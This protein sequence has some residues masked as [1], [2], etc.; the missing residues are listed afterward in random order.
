MLPLG[1][2]SVEGS[3]D[4]PLALKMTKITTTLTVTR[5]I[6]SK[7]IMITKLNEFELVVVL[8]VLMVLVPLEGGFKIGSGTGLGIIL[9]GTGAGTGTG[10]GT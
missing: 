9:T 8:V 7:L 4:A 2:S 6:T 3:L 1:S 10:T 5:R